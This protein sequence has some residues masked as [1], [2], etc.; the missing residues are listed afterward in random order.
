[1]Y[2][3]LLYFSKKILSLPTYTGRHKVLETGSKKW[4]PKWLKNFQS[5][6]ATLATKEMQIII[7]TEYSFPHIKLRDI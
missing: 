6:G 4:K 5:R 2:K 7:L 1:M 3:A